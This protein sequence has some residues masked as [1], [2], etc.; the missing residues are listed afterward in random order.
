MHRA[1]GDNPL[2]KATITKRE[3]ETLEGYDSR[4]IDSEG[5]DFFTRPDYRPR[6]I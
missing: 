2:T 4:I 3:N 6:D 5:K 1:S